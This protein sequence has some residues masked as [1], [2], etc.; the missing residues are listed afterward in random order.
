MF[1]SFFLVGDGPFDHAAGKSI[2]FGLPLGE[3]RDQE[4]PG[5]FDVDKQENKVVL[6]DATPDSE[7]RE[8]V[9]LAVRHC[10]TRALSIEE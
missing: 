6:L 3:K 7:L 2:A 10:P 1:V 5:V 8:R 4:A 9:E